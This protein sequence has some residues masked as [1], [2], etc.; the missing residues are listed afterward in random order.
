MHINCNLW[1][2]HIILYHKRSRKAMASASVTNASSQNQHPSGYQ[3]SSTVFFRTNNL[4]RRPESMAL[5]LFWTGPMKSVKRVE[6]KRPCKQTSQAIV[7]T[8]LTSTFE[9]RGDPVKG[10]KAHAEIVQQQDC[11][12]DN[13]LYSLFTKKQRYYLT[14]VRKL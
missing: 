5:L 4:P 9:V 2:F 13:T 6:H 14:K 3:Q 1:L 7:T 10:G 11:Q 12:E 8:L